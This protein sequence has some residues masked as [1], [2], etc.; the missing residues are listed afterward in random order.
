L[1]VTHDMGVVAKIC[2]N[3]S[4]LYRGHI[5]EQTSASL[6]FSDDCHAYA[7]ALIAAT[8]QYNNPQQALLPIS[9]KVLENL[10]AEIAAIDL[11]WREKQS[12]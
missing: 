11:Q 1:F 8:P 3:V 7:R 2:Q 12:G 10:Q 6:L 4:V 5:V 9:R